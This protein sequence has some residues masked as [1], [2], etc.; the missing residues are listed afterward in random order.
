MTF[1]ARIAIS[2]QDFSWPAQTVA[3]ARPAVSIVAFK[4]AMLIVSGPF[5]DEFA[6]VAR[7]GALSCDFNVALVLV[8]VAMEAGRAS[9]SGIGGCKGDAK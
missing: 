4:A 5:D 3:T 9:H 2:T 6:T 7:G 1:A 8:E